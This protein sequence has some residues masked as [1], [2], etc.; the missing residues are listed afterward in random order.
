MKSKI[1]ASQFSERLEY[2]T[3]SGNAI[4]LGPIAFLN[5]FFNQTTETFYGSFGSGWFELTN[6]NFNR[7]PFVIDG[8]FTTNDAGQTLVDYEIKTNY[9][10]FF[11][12]HGITL[13]V[14]AL[15]LPFIFLPDAGPRIIV[16]IVIVSI[17]V[18]RYFAIYHK[19]KELEEDFIE[20][21]EI[22]YN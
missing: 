2:R 11:W 6:N 1:S 21:F 7:V 18:L 12:I 14:M 22:N 4:Y 9:Y 8:T 10:G 5:L 13:L 19:K 20:I 16:N 15:N 17:F 3:R